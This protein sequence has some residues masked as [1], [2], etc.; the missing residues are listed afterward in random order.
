MAEETKTLVKEPNKLQ[1]NP[2][3][4]H[5]VTGILNEVYLV[6][7]QEFV[8][9]YITTSKG[10]EIEVRSNDENWD[11][12]NASRFSDGEAIKASYL[13]NIAGKTTWIDREG[14][15]Q[16][17]NRADFNLLTGIGKSSQSIFTGEV[18]SRLRVNEK[19]ALFD[20]F[21]DKLKS[22]IISAT[23]EDKEAIGTLFG[24]LLG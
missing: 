18:N 12:R 19:I 13:E 11:T 21:G 2:A 3:K 5:T 20:E 24:S 9:L 1:A 22:E 23:V 16:M 15:V 8:I 14:K 10:E 6:P 4:E 17:H 7:D